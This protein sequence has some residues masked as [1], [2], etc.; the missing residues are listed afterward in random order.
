MR[1]IL[2]PC[3]STLIGH[4]FDCVIVDESQR[5]KGLTANVTQMLIRLQPELRYCLGATPV[6]NDVL[7]LFPIMGWLAVDDWYKGNRRNAAWP[8]ARED[9]GRFGATFKTQERDL[10]QEDV[11]PARKIPRTVPNASEDSPIISSPARLLKLL[12]PNLAFISRVECRAD[13]HPTEDH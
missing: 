3:L 11:N 6:G 9:F 5:C 2:E 1:C 12:K 4:Q 7:D 13:S 10:T 8:Y